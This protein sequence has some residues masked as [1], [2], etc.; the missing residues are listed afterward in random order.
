MF[1]NLKYSQ[2]D[3]ELEFGPLQPLSEDESDEEVASFPD[4]L[5]VLPLK[6]TVMF[7]GVVMPVTIGREK[8]IR[9]VQYAFD[10]H[11]LVAVVSQRDAETDSVTRDNLYDIGTIARILRILRMPD[12]SLTAILQGR[13]RF[14]MLNIITDEPFLQADTLPRDYLGVANPQEFQ[15][16]IALVRDKAI[17]TAELSPNIPNDAAVMLNNIKSD[18]FLLNFVASNMNLKVE[19]KQEILEFF[20]LTQK[21]ERILE[22]LDAELQLL[23]LKGEIDERVRVELDKQQRDYFLNQQLRTIQEELGGN[24]HE[25]ELNVIA[26]RAKSKKWSE[27]IEKH[28]DKELAKLRRMPPQVAEYSMMMNY[29][30]TLLDMP[31]GEMTEDVFD[32]PNVKEVLEGDHFG[33]RDVKERI[34]EHLAVLKLKGDMKSPILLLVGP[35]G[36]GKT[37]LGKSIAEALGRKYVRMS[38]GGVNDEAEIRGHRKTYIGA[39]PGRIIQGMKKSGVDNPVFILD[40]VD[41]VGYSHRGDPSSALLEVLDPEQ[42]IAFQDNYLEVEYDL[43][44]VMFIATANNMWAIP[45]PL[46]DRMEVIHLSGYT[47]EEKVEIAKKH[48]IP[49]QKEKHGLENDS[50][51]ID[52]DLIKSVIRGYTR[53]AGVR[54]LSREMASV[55]RKIALKIANGESYDK[56]LSLDDIKKMLGAPYF[57]KAIDENDQIAGVVTGLVWSTVGGDITFIEGFSVKGNGNINSS[58]NLGSVMRESAQVA[59]NFLRIHS[60]QVGIPNSVLKANDIYLHVPEG[61]VPKEGPSAGITI[62]TAIVSAIRKQPVKKWLAMTGEITLR[63]KLLPVGGI[64]EKVLAARRVGIQEIILCHENRRDIEEIEPQYLEG[65]TFHYCERMLDALK[66]AFENQLEMLPEEKKDEK[67][68]EKESKGEKEVKPKTPRKSRAKKAE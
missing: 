58:G 59:M 11:K 46:R 30:E 38:L 50:V 19:A 47:V 55:M 17:Q 18:S 49:E 28:F 41:K 63:G 5:P 9:A 27:K 68:D 21:A 33:L 61:A 1:D 25:E 13:K 54:A 40:E 14:Q 22:F 57:T 3:D 36:V 45:A 56:K 35:P 31:F 44:K 29:L 7:P 60:D 32:I 51:E 64:K 53:E 43:S 20:D 16:L 67:K 6:N 66:I 4:V 34:L 62:L 2:M 8:S 26:A 37:S 52:D 10:S 15:A 39:M 42:N 23:Q 24:P 12:G 65:L 48:L